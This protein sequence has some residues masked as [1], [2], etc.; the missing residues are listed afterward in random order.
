MTTTRTT[1]HITRR[2]T[3]GR[4]VSGLTG[5]LAGWADSVLDPN[6][7]QP[8]PAPA[9]TGWPGIYLGVG[10]RGPVWAGPEH[11]AL[12]LGPP[13]SGK[14]TRV[15]APNLVLHP[16][17]LVATTTKIDLPS[18]TWAHR[19][20]RG[21]CWWWD[22]TNTVTPPPGARPLRWS[23]VV[24]CETWDQAVTRAHA[25]ASAARPTPAN[26]AGGGA[27]THW[28]ERAQALLAPLL[29]AAA[30]TP[31]AD[32]SDVLTWLHRRELTVP[33]SILEDHGSSLAADL[34]AGIAATDPR[35]SSGIFSTADSLLAAYRTS[36]ALD[37]ARHPNFDPDHFARST[38]TVYLCA[39]ATTQALH[40]PLVIALLDQIRAATYTHRPSPSML[41]ALDEMANIAPLSDLPAT[42][43]EG[44]SQ[45]LTVL[46]CL[47]DLSQARTRWGNA[48]DGFLT[49]FTHKLVLPGIADLATL[50]Q[51]TALAGHTDIPVTSHTRD[52]RLI[53]AHTTTNTSPQR[54]PRL[55]PDTI[56][57]GTPGH[58]L[59]LNRTQPATIRLPTWKWK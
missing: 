50:R 25:L 24:G 29:H 21:T 7:A 40:A 10:Q 46:A 9:V 56:A 49:L 35:E 38:D 41:W 23:P 18:I 20:R 43:S 6:P 32:L 5:R 36:A 54:R 59:W 14:T 15:A 44:A 30:L 33:L 8:P 12:I 45:A 26:T 2:T 11:H 4:V 55:P 51:I 39:P 27:E 47:Q 34:L 1:R 22:P 42:I 19:A 17:P 37:S 52:N 13:R 3:T 28:V 31:A 48:A 16:G 58:A 57:Q 53:G